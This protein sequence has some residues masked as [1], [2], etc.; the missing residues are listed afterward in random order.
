MC[1]CQSSLIDQLH[2][3]VIRPVFIHLIVYNLLMLVVLLQR[4]DKLDDIWDLHE[5]QINIARVGIGKFLFT[6]SSNLSPVPSKHKTSV[7]ERLSPGLG[8]HAL[9]PWGFESAYVASETER[10][11]GGVGNW[12]EL[13]GLCGI[14]VYF[15]FDLGSLIEYVQWA[16]KEQM[17]DTHLDSSY[18]LFKKNPLLQVCW[19]GISGD[20]YKIWPASLGM[21]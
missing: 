15:A 2:S 7:R 14:C 20:G 19:R 18:L 13:V 4:F 8:I 5:R 9:L 11:K 21:N 16:L 12:R 1:L 3:T 6:S 17:C 10:L